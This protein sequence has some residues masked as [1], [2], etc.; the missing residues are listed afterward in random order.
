MEK[1][2]KWERD[3]NGKEW[4]WLKGHKW[5]RDR[6]GK[7]WFWLKGTRVQRT[8]V[9]F[10]AHVLLQFTSVVVG[11]ELNEKVVLELHGLEYYVRNP[12]LGSS[13]TKPNI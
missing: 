11:C 12:S 6:S 8:R 3:R 10:I 7:E 13:S 5:E 9:P 2:H 4:F 1:R